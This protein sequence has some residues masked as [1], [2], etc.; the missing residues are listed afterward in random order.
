MLSKKPWS[1]NE[2][3]LWRI[4]RLTRNETEQLWH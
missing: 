1:L 2:C 3:V 4:N